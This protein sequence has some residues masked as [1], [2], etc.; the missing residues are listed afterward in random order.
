MKNQLHIRLFLLPQP[1]VYQQLCLLLIPITSVL[2]RLLSLTWILTPAS[3]QVSASLHPTVRHLAGRA[4]FLN[5][6]SDL[7]KL[8]VAI[9]MKPNDLSWVSAP[10]PL[11]FASDSL[12]QQ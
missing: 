2:P 12:I 5:L 3:D 7:F 10:S 6:T 4:S 8:C 1:Y 9:G 11:F